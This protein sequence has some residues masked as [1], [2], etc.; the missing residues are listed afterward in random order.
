MATITKKYRILNNIDSPEDLKQLS[1]NDLN[2]LCEEIREYII[3]VVCGCGGHLAPSLGVV[4]LTLALHYVY[5]IPVDKLIFDVGHQCYV[6]KIVTGRREAFK[7]VRQEG[8]IS[9]FPHPA[10]SPCDAF[11]TGHASTSISAAL[12]YATARDIAGK[13][14]EVVAVIG[15]GSLTG[16]LAYE[17]L[18]HA[19][20]SGKK[21]L[22]V[23]N[24]NQM[25]IA[26]NVG[27]FSRYLNNIMLDPRYSRFKSEIWDITEKLP[28]GKDQ[29]RRFAHRMEESLK[30]LIV[31][32]IVFEELGF[33]YFG[34]VE[35]H[36][37]EELVRI[38]RTIRKLDGPILLHVIT[39]KGK[40]YSYA[41]E[42]PTRFHGTNGFDRNTGLSPVSAGAISYSKAF[43]EAA[44][45]LAQSNERITAITAAMPD[46]T[47]LSNFQKELP[48]RFFDVGI[49][50]EHAVT[51]AAGQALAGMR[52]LVALYSTFLQRA[53]DMAVV[54][55]ALQNCPV[56]F[57]I[58]R[59]GVVGDDGPTHN[60][61]FDLS[62]MSMIPG[63]IVSAPR[64][65]I[66]LRDLLYT[67]FLQDEHP[68]S[69]RYP[70][71]SGIGALRT[72]RFKKIEIGSWE[73][74]E[75]GEDVALLAVGT[76]LHTCVWAA[77]LL[78]AEGI[79]PTI[80]N[81][82]FVKP[83]DKKILRKVLE[84][85]RVVVTLEENVLSGGFGSQV[86]M[87]AA[88]NSVK[89]AGRLFHLGVPDE[90]LKHAKR[91]LILERL[92]LNAAGIHKFVNNCINGQAK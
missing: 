63:M 60:G 66:E 15:D 2:D 64:D 44:L 58:D 51:F 81:C 57:G 55:V 34:P 7:W 83:L 12:G 80:V 36:N 28:V 10:E 29:V 1:I 47:G 25:S 65:E 46:G 68:F 75:E 31:P 5:N 32:G 50:E 45:E 21:M 18:N 35:G 49:A 62:F 72:E 82:R 53:I 77:K 74:M 48:D 40:G 67:A 71:G 76:L 9:G 73:V 22:V 42:N 14:Y 33:K 69:I 37:V 4:E 19:G 88:L 16:G 90:F 6:H 39:K 89:M 30:N 61:V 3:G 23:L 70:R 78:R 24:D 8:G 52:P 56:V 41:E 54:D 27:A 11:A 79:S 91:S 26:P 20:A 17:G 84:S 87:F 38:L 92:G 59:A 86:A 13:D 85:H 43:G